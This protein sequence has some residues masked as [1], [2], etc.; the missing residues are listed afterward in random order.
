MAPDAM[1]RQ[2]RA[3]MSALTQ[4]EHTLE[5]VIRS[6]G[7]EHQESPTAPDS[8]RPPPTA[9]YAFKYIERIPMAL[10]AMK[11]QLLARMS[12][13]AQREQ[14]LESVIRSAEQDQQE[15]VAAFK[16]E[17]AASL[18]HLHALPATFV[19]ASRQIDSVH[20]LASNL[21]WRIREVDT[22][23]SRCTEAAAHARYYADLTECLGSIDAHIRAADLAESSASVQRLLRVP[24]DLLTPDDGARVARAREAVLRLLKEAMTPDG[25][26]TPALFNF[27]CECQAAG[28]G[29]ELLANLQY[30]FI[31]DAT[32]ADH[33]ALSQL[34]RPAPGDD[35]PAPHLSAYVKFLDCIAQRVFFFLPH[36]TEP[37][38]LA[39]LI[40]LMLDRCDDRI[41]DIIRK[42]SEFRTISQLPERRARPGSTDLE[43]SMLDRVND[44]IAGFA[45]QWTLFENFLKG[46]L[47]A[48][49]TAPF[50][51]NYKFQVSTRPDTGLPEKQ[52]GAIRALLELLM[53]YVALTEKFLRSAS[54]NLISVVKSLSQTE[55]VTN[56]I[57]DL[58]YVYHH[59]LGRSI[60]THS[61]TATCTIFNV[62]TGIIHSELAPALEAKAQERRKLGDVTG[63]AGVLVNAY[64]LCAQLVQK[65]VTVTKPSI[66][67]EF[68]DHEDLSLI[69]SGLSDLRQSGMALEAGLKAQ[70]DGITNSLSGAPQELVLPFTAIRWSDKTIS[71][72]TEAKLQE[73]FK[74]QFLKVFGNY[75]KALSD[76]NFQSLMAV[77][78]PVFAQ[79]LEE[80]IK[81]KKFSEQGV[82]LLKRALPL[83]INLFET[84]AP[85]QRLADI[86]TVL[87]LQAP[88]DIPRVWGSRAT[89]TNP[90]KFKLSELKAIV[91]LRT[92]WGSNDLGFLFEEKAY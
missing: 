1:T 38:H 79:K 88:E 91:A 32:R 26:D 73:T 85:F 54:S 87:S 13:L 39:V 15:S 66:E 67:G 2:L 71:A 81:G 12:G 69:Q 31:L 5:S 55:D 52:Q 10:E 35:S 7:Q 44:E 59:V 75:K 22:A 21:S 86:V 42:F 51:V 74:A 61:V 80:V 27:F 63:K 90:V 4:R 41:T 40:R 47:R 70:I 57:V 45:K 56:A 64:A 78:A 3:R 28:E 92:E 29:L 20:G 65:L 58:F 14:A 6:T 84:E 53:S 62:I 83:L 46:K 49:I 48:G 72:Q 30:Q 68:P 18:G 43:L 34:P 33:V 82:I 36:L 37:G 77:F 76:T 9:S 25:A 8:K 89:V 16:S 60:E 11:Q 19:A 23:I 50:F 24:P 17:I